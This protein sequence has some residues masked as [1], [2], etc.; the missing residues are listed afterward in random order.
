MLPPF[1]AREEGIVLNLNDTFQFHSP[2]PCSNLLSS[3]VWYRTIP[4]CHVGS[5][6]A[7]Q[8]WG[9]FGVT[10]EE[11]TFCPFGKEMKGELLKTKAVRG[12]VIV[13]DLLPRFKVW[14]GLWWIIDGTIRRHLW[15]WEATTNS[16]RCGHQSGFTMASHR[17]TIW[18]DAMTGTQFNVPCSYFLHYMGQTRQSGLPRVG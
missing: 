8:E 15:Y 7:V 18:L 14:S 3:K 10:P 12:R 9:L 11:A 4:T 16:V 5:L 17:Y 13:S 6:T 2:F 1:Q